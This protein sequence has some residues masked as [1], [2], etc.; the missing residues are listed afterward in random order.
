MIHIVSPSTSYCTGLP[1]IYQKAPSIVEFLRVFHSR[2]QPFYFLIPKTSIKMPTQ[3]IFLR[4]KDG[5]NLEDV[6][7][8]SKT[9][10]KEFL[11]LVEIAKSTEGLA[12]QYWVGFYRTPFLGN[13]LREMDRVTKSKTQGYSAG[14]LVCVP[15]S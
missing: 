14:S 6:I 11:E 8:S 13:R 10:A 1:K 9:E 4:V 3:T 5:V 2:S 12:Q 15:W 7:S